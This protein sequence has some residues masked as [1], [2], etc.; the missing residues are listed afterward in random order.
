MQLSEESQAGGKPERPVVQQ[1]R[2][3]AAMRCAQPLRI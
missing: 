3:A 1:H 2:E